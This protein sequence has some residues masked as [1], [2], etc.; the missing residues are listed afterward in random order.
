MSNNQTELTVDEQELLRRIA[1]GSVRD[2]YS[3]KGAPGIL[4]N[5][6]E[7][8]PKFVRDVE[9]K[10]ELLVGYAQKRMARGLPAIPQDSEYSRD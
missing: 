7:G 3:R 9:E 4:P 8:G 10:Y 1:L 2:T 5:T 6:L